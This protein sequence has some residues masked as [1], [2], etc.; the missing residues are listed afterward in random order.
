[1]KA[2]S[3]FRVGVLAFLLCAV[4]FLGL[5]LWQPV[6]LFHWQDLRTGDQIISRVEAF[7]RA[8]KYLPETLKEVGLDNPDLKVFYRKISEDEYCVWFGTSLGESETYSSRARKW[9]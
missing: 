3:S 8:H 7:R 5:F 9:E 1:M 6:W 4:F 2:L